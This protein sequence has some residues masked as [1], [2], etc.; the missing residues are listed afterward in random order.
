[1]ETK[2]RGDLKSE[3]TYFEGDQ[4]SRGTIKKKKLKKII[5]F[6]AFVRYDFPTGPYD[7]FS[8]VF[9]TLL[10][11]GETRGTEESLPSLATSMAS[12]TIFLKI[13]TE[14]K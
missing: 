5:T 3:G 7:T 13:G 14:P 11:F 9:Y 1:M 4:V 2:G 8:M 6:S 10:T 12:L